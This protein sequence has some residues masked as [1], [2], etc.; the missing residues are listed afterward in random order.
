MYN[1]RRDLNMKLSE[2]LDINKNTHTF[3]FNTLANVF[4]LHKIA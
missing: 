4:C 2:K 1:I 3:K